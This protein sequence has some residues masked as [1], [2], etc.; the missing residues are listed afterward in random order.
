MDTVDELLIEVA[1]RLERQVRDA[2]TVAR[3]GGDEF[4]LILEGTG[5]AGARRVAG[6]VIEELRAIAAVGERVL[7]IAASVG[8]VVWT[9]AA[10]RMEAGALLDQADAAMYEAKRAGKGRYSIALPG[11]CAGRP[12]TTTVTSA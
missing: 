9:P 6:S 1:R 2:D 10:G 7:S 4:V 11:R 8:V 12:V 3:L 5:E